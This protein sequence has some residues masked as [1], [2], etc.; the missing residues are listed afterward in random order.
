MVSA[1]LDE[2]GQANCVNA[3]LDFCLGALQEDFR[4][5]AEL[6]FRARDFVNRMALAMQTAQLVQNAPPFVAGA[7]CA[8]RL[9]SAGHHN[10]GTL[11]LGV[12]C[13]ATIERATPKA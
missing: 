1:L 8:S 3:N 10:Y 13:A 2:V 9:G 11:P 4:D 6:E 5:L 7:F 12:D